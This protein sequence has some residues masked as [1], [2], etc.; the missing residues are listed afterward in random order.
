MSKALM[1]LLGFNFAPTVMR[2]KVNRDLE[3]REKSVLL[4]PFSVTTNRSLKPG[5]NCSSYTTTWL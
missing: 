1:T 3:N 5:P 4:A 2:L